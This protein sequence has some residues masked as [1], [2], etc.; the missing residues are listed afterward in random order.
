MKVLKLEEGPVMGIE[1][2][3]HLNTNVPEPIK[4][5]KKC[6]QEIEINFPVLPLRENGVVF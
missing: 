2:F 6:V 1:T 4:I 3:I 5:L